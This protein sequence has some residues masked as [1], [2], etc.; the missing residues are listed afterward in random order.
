MKHP[1]I[2]VCP[3]IIRRFASYYYKYDDT[4]TH[5]W[6]MLPNQQTAPAKRKFKSQKAYDHIGNRTF[7]LPAPLSTTIPKHINLHANVRFVIL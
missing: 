3:L 4:D 2:E 5:H 7:I 1:N 6:F